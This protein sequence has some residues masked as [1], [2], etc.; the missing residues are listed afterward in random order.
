MATESYTDIDR[1]DH[2]PDIAAAL[3][4]MVVAWA[5]AET[6]MVFAFAAVCG[7]NGN[8][9]HFGYYRIPTFDARTKVI[10]AMLAEWETTKYDR[11][12]I[13][14]AIGK[15]SHLSKARNEWIHAVWCKETKGT[16]TVVFDFRK[17]DGNGRRKPVKA[18]DIINH[19]I[20]VRART[21]ELRKL[22]PE[23]RVMTESV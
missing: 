4:N 11:D 2:A 9:A 5:N 21:I 6:A 19:I 20:A 18:A 15:L 23:S 13:A 10:R 12:A 22:V 1:L 14:T 17:P 8:F 7:I 3:G 16:D